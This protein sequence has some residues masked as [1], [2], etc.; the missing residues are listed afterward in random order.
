MIGTPSVST[1]IGIEGLGLED[2]RHVLVGN[3][4]DAFAAQIAR[5]IDDAALWERVSA[6]GR[7]CIDRTH[8]RD[9]VRA[10]FQ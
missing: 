9:I 1:R 10:Q 5:L 6:E 3:D 2:G 8:G 7:T 4:A